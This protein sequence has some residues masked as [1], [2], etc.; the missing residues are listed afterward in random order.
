[1]AQSIR[2]DGDISTGN[3]TPTPVA[4]EID[5]V[6]PSDSDFVQSENDPANDTFEVSLDNPGA[7]PDTGTGTVRIRAAKGQSGGGSPGVINH[8]VALYEGAT[9]RQGF[10]AIGSDIPTGFAEYTATITSGNMGT[11]T[12]WTD[13]RLR[14]RADKPS[15]ARTS[16][17]EISHAVFEI[18][19][20]AA[21]GERERLM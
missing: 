20:A 13:V 5:E 10:T 14:F 12:D 4:D 18:P 17:G 2:P 9:Q 8:E 19:D 1:M 6:T 7:T 21:A 11:V 16:W 15:G 3:W